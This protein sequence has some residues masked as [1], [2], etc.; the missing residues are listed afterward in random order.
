MPKEWRAEKPKSDADYFER[1]NRSIFQAGLNYKMIEKKWP[2]FRRAFADFSIEKV[3]KFGE[4]DVGRL[5]KDAG[6]VRNE[7]KIRSAI[8][9]AQESLRVGKKFGS[10][11]SYLSSFKADETGLVADLQKRFGHLGESSARMFLYMSGVKLTPT[12]E[13]RQW[14]ERSKKS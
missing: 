11:H 5:M 7:R 1:M 12:R 9:N 3:A 13:E 4:R 14:M 10:F 8:A 2:N 6:I